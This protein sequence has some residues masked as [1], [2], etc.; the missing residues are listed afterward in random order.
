MVATLIKCDIGIS[1]T[2]SRC[3]M[4]LII[5]FLGIALV[6]YIKA[7]IVHAFLLLYSSVHFGVDC[8]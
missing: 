2:R 6:T 8:D 3:C 7:D 5:D 4:L 1:G